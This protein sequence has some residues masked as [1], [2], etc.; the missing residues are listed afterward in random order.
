MTVEAVYKID[1]D[2]L[3]ISVCLLE[4]KRTTN[5]DKPKEGGTILVTLKRIKD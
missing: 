3:T 5:F 4:K 2:T 1:G